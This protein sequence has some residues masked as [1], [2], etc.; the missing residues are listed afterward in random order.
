MTTGRE[1]E[2][3]LA[4][5]IR[6]N[7]DGD[8]EI[9]AYMARPLGA[10][11][12]PGVIVIHHMPGWDDAT[13]EITRKFAHS[14]YIGIDPNLHFR[15]GPGEPDDVSAVVRDAGGVPDARCVGDVQGAMRHLRSLP[16]CNGK[17]GISDGSMG[18]GRR[19]K[20]KGRR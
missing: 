2:G 1:Y 6:I 7:G 15:E 11:P 16:Y 14:G 9:G 18:N 13:K 4:E 17:I 8:D 19:Q 12:Y 10:G 5:T 3:L 20:S